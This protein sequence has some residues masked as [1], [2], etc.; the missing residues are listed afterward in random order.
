MSRGRSRS[1][2]QPTT[3]RSVQE[4]RC[5]YTLN[6]VAPGAMGVVASAG[7][8]LATAPLP[9]ADAVLDTLFVASGQGVEEAAADAALVDWVR[10][11]ATHARRV[12]SVCI[13]AFLLAATACWTGGAR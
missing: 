6:V 4:T 10:L 7:L 9:P 1:L 11:R 12:A 2:P 3:L 5:P 8:E 13:G